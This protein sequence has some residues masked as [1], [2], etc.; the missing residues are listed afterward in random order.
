MV[1]LWNFKKSG[2]VRSRSGLDV[3]WRKPLWV[4]NIYRR[5]ITLPKISLL[6]YPA[7]APEVLNCPRYHQLRQPKAPAFISC[8]SFPFLLS[9]N[10]SHSSPAPCSLFSS[11]L[12]T[13][14]FSSQMA[15]GAARKF[16]QVRCSSWRSNGISSPPNAHSMAMTSW[17]TLQ[18][19]LVCEGQESKIE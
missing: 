7:K 15:A 8:A 4:E 14:K 5:K 17:F 11:L 16:W 6:F 19:A 2:N 10:P 3:I 9:S 12:R 13:C 1:S 18:L